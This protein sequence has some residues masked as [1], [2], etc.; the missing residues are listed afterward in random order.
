M[1][2]QWSTKAVIAMILGIAGGF[3]CPII[4]SSAGVVLGLMAQ[5]EGDPHGRT[6]AITSA[7]ILGLGA[8]MWSIIILG[9]L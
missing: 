1:K 7:V 8:V 6:A 3:F 5:N 4:L 9:D 2:D